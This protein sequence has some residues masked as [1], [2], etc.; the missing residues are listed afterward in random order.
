MLLKLK[1][2]FNIS[3]YCLHIFTV[4]KESL[5]AMIN[6]NPC[7][8]SREKKVNFHFIIQK[9]YSFSL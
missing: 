6:K 4:G 3:D 5:K 8:K 7:L 2:F 9:Y 1:Q